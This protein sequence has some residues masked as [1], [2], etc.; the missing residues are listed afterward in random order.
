MKRERRVRNSSSSGSTGS[1]GKG[2]VIDGC[3][4]GIEDNEPTNETEQVSRETNDGRK[5]E[6]AELEKR[7]RAELEERER[8]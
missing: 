7:E 2:E 6:R 1:T 3:I 4:I 8:E 5:N